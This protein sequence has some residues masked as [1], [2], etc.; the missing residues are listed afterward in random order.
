MF[1]VVDSAIVFPEGRLPAAG[2]RTEYATRRVI[3]IQSAARNSA[4][5]PKTILVVP[6]SSFGAGSRGDVKIP[7]GEVGFD[8]PN[9]VALLNLIQPILK[10][11]LVSC[12]GQLS[13][14]A[15]LQMQRALLE[16]IGLEQLIEVEL[17][18]REP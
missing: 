6:C 2:E 5:S 10:S 1:A 12:L 13:G 17:P 8:A 7:K 11:E 18:P 15:L 16:N 3:V 9:V 4:V 14:S